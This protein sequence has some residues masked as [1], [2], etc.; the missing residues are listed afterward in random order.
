MRIG[1]IFVLLN[2]F[3]LQEL[4][5]A[6][7]VARSCGNLYNSQL[8]T[9]RSNKIRS[10]AERNLSQTSTRFGVLFSGDKLRFQWLESQQKPAREILIKDIMPGAKSSFR[11]SD[12]IA[13]DNVG[14]GRVLLIQLKDKIVRWDMD[15]SGPKYIYNASLKGGE[16]YIFNSLNQLVVIG[17]AKIM[18]SQKNTLGDSITYGDMARV[19]SKD[20]TVRIIRYSRDMKLQKLLKNPGRD[21]QIKD[22]QIFNYKGREYFVVHRIESEQPSKGIE[23][24]NEIVFIGSSLAK[25]EIISVEQFRGNITAKNLSVGTDKMSVQDRISLSEFNIAEINIPMSDKPIPIHIPVHRA[26]G[27]FNQSP[28]SLLNIIQ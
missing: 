1:F 6:P 10:E 28:L 9:D 22:A 27:Y 12:I 24:K 13:L 11:S 23:R 15:P 3:S 2:L 26:F 19:Y 14:N 4:L 18:N 5:A 7:S 8:K 25:S 21:I 16:T 20:S 17:S